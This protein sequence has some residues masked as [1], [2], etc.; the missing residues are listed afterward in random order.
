MMCFLFPFADNVHFQQSTQLIEALVNHNVQFRLQV[1]LLCA[2][3]CY[4]IYP[5]RLLE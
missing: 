4:Q 5:T 3:L 1:R 2:F